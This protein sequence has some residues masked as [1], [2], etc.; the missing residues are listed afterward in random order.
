MPKIVE[1][2]GAGGVGKS[3]VCREL[4][5]KE[6]RSGSQNIMIANQ[7]KVSFFDILGYSVSHL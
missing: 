1:F 5:K 3:H 2:V 7:C 6:M 4:L